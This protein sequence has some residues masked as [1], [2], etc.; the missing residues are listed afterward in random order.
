M[1]VAPLMHRF[2]FSHRLPFKFIELNLNGR[3]RGLKVRGQEWLERTWEPRVFERV[4][5]RDRKARPYQAYRPDFLTERPLV[6]DPLLGQKI[7]RIELNAQPND[8]PP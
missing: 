1:S 8:L 4:A 2:L 3:R 5:R 7:A 6:V